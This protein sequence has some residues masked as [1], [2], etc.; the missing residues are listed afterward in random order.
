M[1]LFHYLQ[2]FVKWLEPDLFHQYV[3]GQYMH[4]RSIYL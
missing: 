1:V 4:M 3:Y 2:V